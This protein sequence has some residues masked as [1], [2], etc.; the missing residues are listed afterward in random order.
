MRLPGVRRPVRALGYG[1]RGT[2][3][4][5]NRD[6]HG[7]PAYPPQ[8]T[9]LILLDHRASSGAGAPDREEFCR[10]LAVSA[11]LKLEICLS[12]ALVSTVPDF[13]PCWV[14]AQP[15]DADA[16]GR[17]GA[18]AAPPRPPHSRACAWR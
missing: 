2:A 5:E 7:D 14:N 17:G 11:G 10:G 4:C 8:E 3:G 12:P 16:V 13:C 6:L 15:H 1:Y 18:G 9:L